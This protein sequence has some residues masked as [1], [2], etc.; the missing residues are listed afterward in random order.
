VVA[1]REDVDRHLREILEEL[2]GQAEPSRGVL[3]VDDREVN[4]LPV[5]DPGQRLGERAAPRGADD[6]ADEQDFQGVRRPA[7]AAL[8]R[9]ISRIR[10]LASPGSP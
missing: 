2:D 6:V 4:R 8:A 10:P 7:R 3:D 5:D 1:R 9:L